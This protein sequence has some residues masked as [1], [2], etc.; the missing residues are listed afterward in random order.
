M[1][2]SHCQ[3]VRPTLVVLASTYPRWHGDPEPAFVHELSRRLVRRFRVLAIVPDAPGADQ[4]G[5]HDGVEVIRFR[6]APRRL[7]TLVNDGGIVSNLRR[8]RWKLLLLPAF[9]LA[10]AWSLWRLL[11]KTRVDAIHAH[12]LIPQGLIAVLLRKL[13]RRPPALLVTSHGADLFALR[14]YGMD[15]LKR[16]VIKNAG[17]VSVVSDAMR[18]ELARIGAPME[19][20]SVK[21]MGVDLA[22]SF[23]PDAMAPRSDCE[24]LFVGRLVEKKG[25]RYL[26]AAMP[27]V[28]EKAPEAH[29]TIVGF[30]PEADDLGCQV[31]RLNLG[32]KV[33]FVGALPQAMLPAYYQRAALFVAPFVEAGS[34]DQEGLGLVAVEAA[35]CGCPVVL[36]DVPGAHGLLDPSCAKFVQPRNTAEFAASIIE[37]LEDKSERE[38]LAALARERVAGTVDWSVVSKGYIELLDRIVR[39]LP[40]DYSA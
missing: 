27:E 8:S 24:L 36:G 32:N 29:L 1:T 40:R 6:Y 33:R 23:K 35:G 17:A 26:L 38:R 15:A 3:L 2:D 4:S 9:F 21:P 31:A 13:M 22:D 25:L 5:L 28:L 34:G 14:G 20:V 37:L 12:W 11:R 19:K 7:Q 16:F 39:I 30:G 10:Q 18:A